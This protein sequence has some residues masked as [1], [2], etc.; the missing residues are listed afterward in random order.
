MQLLPKRR[1]KISRTQLLAAK[2]V[3]LVQSQPEPAGEGVWRVTVPMRPAPWAR[4]FLRAQQSITKK[5]ELDELGLFV[6][7]ACDGRT[8]VQQVIRRLGKQ[9]N[10]NTRAAEVS[11]LAFL[12]TLV[13]K[14]LMGVKERSRE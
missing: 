7:N 6:W 4:V 10:L 2:P 12:Q 5:F 14:G 1:P 9:Y 13:K 8:S 3:R 11:T